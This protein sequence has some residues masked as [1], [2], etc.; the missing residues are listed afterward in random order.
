MKSPPISRLSIDFVKNKVKMIIRKETEKDYFEV[1]NLTREAFWNVYRPG[2]TEHLVL[3]NLRNDKCFVKDLDYVIEKDGKIIANIV[4]ALAKIVDGESEKEVLIFGPVSVSPEYQK[5]GYGE[6]IINFTLEKAKDL[7]Y[8]AVIITGSPDYYGRFGFE[9]CSS[10][11]IYYEGLPKDNPAPFFM[12]KILDEN[13]AK[14]LKGVYADPSCY[15]VDEKALE[16]FDGQFP[17]KIKEVK[18]GQLL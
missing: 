5:Q 12:I 16:K 11:G 13:K 8:P 14:L 2:C 9:S 6:K 3:H 1:E 18:E 7:G 17:P 10:Y 15:T 4:Y